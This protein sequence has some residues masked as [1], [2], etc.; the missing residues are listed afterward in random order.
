MAQAFPDGQESESQEFPQ[1]LA[2]QHTPCSLCVH[3]H[4]CTF[5]LKSPDAVRFWKWLSQGEEARIAYPREPGP[6]LQ[7]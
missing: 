6:V 2:F 4:A 1:P 7:H 3:V 5:S